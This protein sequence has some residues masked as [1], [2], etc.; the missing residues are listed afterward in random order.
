MEALEVDGISLGY[1]AQSS[2]T[3]ACPIPAYA[4]RGIS[5]YLALELAP[6]YGATASTELAKKYDEGM[7]TIKRTAINLRLE[8]ADMSHLPGGTGRYDILTDEF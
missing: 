6:I 1:F 2:T 3:D 8:G 4:E 7:A 5:A